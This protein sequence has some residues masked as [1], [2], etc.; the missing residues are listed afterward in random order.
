MASGREKYGHCAPLILQV[1]MSCS[2][3]SSKGAYI[4]G[5]IWD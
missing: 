3:N 2:L 5:D 4:G 1:D